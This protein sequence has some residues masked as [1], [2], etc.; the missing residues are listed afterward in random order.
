RVPEERITM[1]PGP[2]ALY[3]T[4][5]NSPELHKHDISSLRL[6]VTGAAS[7][8]VEL[9]VRMRKELPFET[10][11]TG[12]GLT[13]ATGIATMCRHDDDPDTIAKT[14]G[15]PI[16][17]VEVRVVDDDGRTVGTGEPG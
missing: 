12:Y 5:L 15:R 11:V 6:A 10:V 9:I 4:I 13:E 17:G 3:Q 8:P 1:P 16:P 7:I 14:V 2:P